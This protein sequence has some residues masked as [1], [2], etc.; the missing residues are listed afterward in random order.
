LQVVAV[1]PAD[2]WEQ[3]ALAH[4]IT[5]RA[6]SQQVAALDSEVGYVRKALADKAAHAQALEARL[7]SCQGELRE[8][9]DKVRALPASQ[10]CH[11]D[12][13]CGT[14]EQHSLTAASHASMHASGGRYCS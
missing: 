5:C 3:L 7:A 13:A 12:P 8:A 11:E 2:P 9:L 1:L 10:T 6:Y 14:T 4:R